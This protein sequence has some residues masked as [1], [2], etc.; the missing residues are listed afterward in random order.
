MYL[1][2]LGEFDI[3]KFGKVALPLCYALFILNSLFNTIVMLNLMIA[4]IGE[5][6]AKVKENS[7]NAMYQEMATLIAENSYL[8]P[9][10]IRENYA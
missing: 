1:V 7:E 5:S 4:I 2:I 10:N 8:V 3:D 6:F 9:K